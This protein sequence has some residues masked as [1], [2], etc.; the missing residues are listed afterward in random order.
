VTGQASDE[1]LGEDLFPRVVLRLTTTKVAGVTQSARG[2]PFEERAAR[3]VSE[4]GG[5]DDVLGGSSFLDSA[6]MLS[7][8]VSAPHTMQGGMCSYTA[9][10]WWTI[11]P[12]LVRAQWPL[13]EQLAIRAAADFEAMGVPYVDGRYMRHLGSNMPESDPMVWACVRG[14]ARLCEPGKLPV[15]LRRI[16]AKEYVAAARHQYRDLLGQLID[17][18]LLDFG[19]QL[20]TLRDCYIA[21]C[22]HDGVD[23]GQLS[24]RDIFDRARAASDERCDFAFAL[25]EAARAA[26]VRYLAVDH[27][28]E[29][30]ALGGSMP[31]E[32]FAFLRKVGFMGRVV[33]N[34][35]AGPLSRLACFMVNAWQA[36]V[37]GA[38][39]DQ[40]ANGE[41]VVP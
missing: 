38:L 34:A 30:V 14:A 1:T 41:V 36:E 35:N 24:S 7:I 37:T 20:P 3:L 31:T 16:T 15:Q 13:I 19:Q 25:W 26:Q 27:G 32:T 9:A 8:A 29:V 28:V 10:P 22:K 39:R 18:S 12:A 6:R 5:F 11:D 33:G 17:E 21:V 2:E 40:P 23:P 4:F